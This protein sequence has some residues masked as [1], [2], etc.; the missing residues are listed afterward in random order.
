MRGDIVAMLLYEAKQKP[1]IQYLVDNILSL[2][3][4]D[5]Q[6]ASTPLPWYK[7]AL[8]IMKNRLTLE[9]TTSYSNNSDPIG[10]TALW[11]Y[12]NTFLKIDR[13]GEIE[14]KT[15]T[16]IWFQLNSPGVW[17]ESLFSSTIDP[18]LLTL[19]Q[20]HNILK[21][22]YLELYKQRINNLI[23][24]STIDMTQGISS[25]PPFTITRY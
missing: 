15:N 22:Q 18:I 17:I 10:S 8:L 24:S 7:Q 5:I 1:N 19:P 14:I 23:H 21:S 13:G 11:T 16:P 9:S 6:N 12:D 25:K 3:T 4:N 2:S 20:S